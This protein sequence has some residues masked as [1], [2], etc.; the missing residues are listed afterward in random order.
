MI[1]VDAN[2]RPVPGAE[3]S[4]FQQTGGEDGRYILSGT[5]RSDAQG[6]AVCAEAIFTN[7]QGNFDRWIYARVPGRLVGVGRCAKWTNRQVINSEGR[8]LLQPS[9]SVE[10]QV[11]VPAGFDPTKV[12][13]RVQNLSVM[14]GLGD[15]NW[16]SFPRESRFPGLDTALPTIL[17]C[18]P[19][20][21][22]RI[23]FD[24]VPVS[25]WLYLVTA[26]AGLGEAQ[27]R[28]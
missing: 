3:V 26:G 25:G 1:C 20:F 13:V 8:V 5:F 18:R 21:K 2:G 27:W 23:R 7:E 24:D 22:G 17:D 16:E 12:M 4:L 6:K 19:D 28:N 10:G 15:F 9:R 14:T 11:T